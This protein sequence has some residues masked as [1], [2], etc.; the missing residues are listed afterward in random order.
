MTTPKP[1]HDRDQAVAFKRPTVGARVYLVESGAGWVETYVR[2][3]ADAAIAKFLHPLVIGDVLGAF[4][5]AMELEADK[6]TWE[7]VIGFLG[8]ITNRTASTIPEI[9]AVGFWGQLI[10]FEHQQ[11][12]N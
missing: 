9:V 5:T 3:E 7:D 11:G 12:A 2:K 6:E 1:Y 8:K 4:Q 10:T